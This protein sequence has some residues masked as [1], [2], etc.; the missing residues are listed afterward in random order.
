MTDVTDRLARLDG[1]APGTPTD[2]TVQTDLARGRAA[3]TRRRRGRVAAAG[4]A[5]ALVAAC[6][7]GVTATLADGDG[8]GAG[9]DAPTI[10]RPQG[11]PAQ[12][13]QPDPAI[14]LVAYRG[15]QLPGFEVAAVPEGFVLQGADEFT[16]TVARP[17]DDSH[18]LDFRRKLVVSLES[19]SA[20]AGE[21]D[22][23]PVTVGGHPGAIRTTTGATILEYHDGTHEVVVQAWEGIGLTDEQLVE[24]AE[25]ITVTSSVKAPVG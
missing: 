25:G 16:L 13:A 3:L 2:A 1:A 7:Y 22:G 8:D 18:Y 4:A 6:G 19:R 9:E 24:F 23:E 15:A 12:P 11:Q 17:G 10:A 20:P 21:A 5:L 14:A